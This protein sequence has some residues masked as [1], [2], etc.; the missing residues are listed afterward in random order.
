MVE[1]RVGR[2][3]GRLFLGL[4]VIAL[5]ALWTL[6]NLDILDSE[7]ILRWWPLLIVAV[8]LGK[9][10]GVGT[11]R[12]TAAGTVLLIVGAW[13]LAGG[14]GAHWVD[15]SLLWP[16]VLVVI[17]VN[18]VIRSYRTQA[19]GGSS[20]E[21]GDRVGTFAFW[22]KIDRNVTSQAFRGG[23]V[24]AVMGG[25]KIDLRNAKLAPEG[26]VIDLFV[27]W[28]GVDLRVPEDWKVVLTGNVLMGGIEDKA[29]APPIDT[30]NVLVLQGMVLMGG[31]DIKN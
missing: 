22:S 30:K 4:V 3:S 10:L 25:A 14:L 13:L 16:V 23:D 9:M 6:D 18:L 12:N 8:G 15:L 19:L 27:W 11:T 17:G 31:I 26:A 2:L 7:P 1:V 28:G 24:T 20:E 21:V 29:K 5:G